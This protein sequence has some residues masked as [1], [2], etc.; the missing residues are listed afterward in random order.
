M[1]NY[2]RWSRKNKITKKAWREMCYGWQR[3]LAPIS[4]ML[5]PVIGNGR[6][7]DQ[8]QLTFRSRWGYRLTFYFGRVVSEKYLPPTA[9]IQH[10]VSTYNQTIGLAIQAS[11]LVAQYVLPG[12]VYVSSFTNDKQDDV[13]EWSEAW[14]M[15]RYAAKDFQQF[16]L[17][18]LGIVELD[19]SRPYRRLEI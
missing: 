19:E 9:V 8:E 5:D 14:D 13:E 11:L 7:W 4:T 1:P 6:L 15:C 17:A 3:A 12:E 2:I 18:N 16:K 10:S